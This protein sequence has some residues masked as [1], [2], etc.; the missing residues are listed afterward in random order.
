MKRGLLI[1][2]GSVSTTLLVNKLYKQYK[3]KKQKRILE[4]EPFQILDPFVN[5]Y[6]WSTD[7]DEHFKKVISER[8]T[9][10]E[11]KILKAV[12]KNREESL[13]GEEKIAYYHFLRIIDQYLPVESS[14]KSLEELN[15]KNIPR[16]MTEEDLRE[17]DY[18]LEETE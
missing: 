11:V 8:M 16:N 14:L 3:K 15:Q 9:L 4:E 5:Y 1:S 10:D 13:R 6:Y 12:F 7:I 17:L 2:I 18:L